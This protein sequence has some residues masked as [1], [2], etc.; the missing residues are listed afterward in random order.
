M[1]VSK[2]QSAQNRQ[3]LLEAAGRLYRE[4]G[5][6]GV[7]VAEISRQAGFTHGGF[8]GRFDSKE[9]LAAEASAQA[10]TQSLARL[11]A[12]LDRHGG[13]AAPYIQQ[14]LRP[15]HR[16]AAG[17]GCAIA[18]LAVDAARSGGALAEALTEGIAGYLAA[19]AGSPAPSEAAKSRA[20]LS[21]SALVG[22]LVLARA[23]AGA[24]PALSD[25]ILARLASA[26]GELWP[27]G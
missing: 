16:D 6:G 20:V 4:R 15:Q 24:A 11:Q 2:A 25:E 3:A 7:G 17:Q 21:L 18:A 27:R 13:D 23:T 1:K 14:Y 22:G 9:A 12:S 10:L 19:L 8:Y 26:L 5:I